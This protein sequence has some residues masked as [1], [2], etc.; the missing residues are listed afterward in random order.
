ML[1]F[2]C[3]RAPSKQFRK[4]HTGKAEERAYIVQCGLF[5][6]KIMRSS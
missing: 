3:H 6:Y 2:L 4:C 5:N 1:R